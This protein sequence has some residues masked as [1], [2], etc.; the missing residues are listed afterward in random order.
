MIVNTLTLPCTDG[1]KNHLP[2]HDDKQDFSSVLEK[3]WNLTRD[4]PVTPGRDIQPDTTFSITPLT[5]EQAKSEE[6]K[7]TEEALLPAELLFTGE[8]QP[9]DLQQRVLQLAASATACEPA[10]G[11]AS[12]LPVA[13]D[14]LPWPSL[15]SASRERLLTGPNVMAGKDMEHGSSLTV[16]RS[17]KRSIP[18][19]GS[20]RPDGDAP[21]L[22]PVTEEGEVEGLHAA[23]T[24]MPVASVTEARPGGTSDFSLRPVSTTAVTGYAERDAVMLPER[25]SN[26]LNHPLGSPQWQQSLGQHLTFFTRQGIHNAELHLHPEEL[27]SLQ[28]TMRLHQDQAQL[29]VLTD[30]PQVRAVLE[31]AM[32]HLRASLAESGIQLGQSSVDNGAG[33]SGDT[34]HSAG[35]TVELAVEVEEAFDDERTHSVAINSGPYLR[36]INTFV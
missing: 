27:G 7:E 24:K 17:D 11:S 16:A 5:S 28:I 29:H 18:G 8:L 23:S 9:E 14:V 31:A 25:V 1:K 30:N 4:M 10:T 21:L 35:E 12:R 32:P 2:G 15:E 6:T 19:E 20:P 26:T 22:S 33:S 36:G 3:K 34:T 13:D